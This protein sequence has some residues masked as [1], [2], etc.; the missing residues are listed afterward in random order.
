MMSHIEQWQLK[1]ALRR[2][3]ERTMERYSYP[4]MLNPK[5]PVPRDISRP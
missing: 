2:L 5:Y 1:E 4:T 3:D